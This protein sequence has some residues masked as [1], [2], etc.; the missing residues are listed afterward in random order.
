MPQCDNIRMFKL[1]HNVLSFLIIR[2]KRARLNNP[3]HPHEKIMK[4]T[5]E[6][7]QILRAIS[8]NPCVSQREIALK[9]RISLGKVNYAIKSLI[10][11]GYVKIL[12]FQGSKN[13]RKYMY[14][15]TPTGMFEKAKLTSD[16]LKWKMEEYERIKKEIEELEEDI[17]DHG[18]TSMQVPHLEIDRYSTEKS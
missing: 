12:N 15:L 3:L 18:L 4:P 11:K 6:S 10:E 16:F 8:R 17:N 1:E 14:I 13:K 2:V 5:I 7:T 9:N